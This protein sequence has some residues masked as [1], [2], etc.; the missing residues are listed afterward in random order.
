MIEFYIEDNEVVLSSDFS[1]NWTEE[2]PEVTSDGEFSLDMTISLVPAQNVIAFG[3][4]NRLNKASITKTVTAKL[5][6]DGGIHSGTFVISTNNNISVVGQFLSGNSE[7]KY[8]AKNENKIYDLDWGTETEIDYIRALDSINQPG[9]GK[10]NF[11]CTPVI[12]SNE[13]VN[14]YSIS[15]DT[16]ATPSAINGITGKIVMQPWLLYYINKLPELLGYTLT[17]NVLNTDKRSKIMYLLNSS[18]SLKYSDALPD[19]T[20]TEF[21][22]YI[23]QFFNVSFIVDPATK[24][25]SI[26]SLESNL[27]NKKTVT[28]VVLD[29][30]EREFDKDS[31]SLRLDFTRVSYDLNDSNYFRW[32][33]LSDVILKNYTIVDYANLDAIKTWLKTHSTDDAAPLNIIFYDVE[34]NNHYIHVTNIQPA[35]VLY[36]LPI[37]QDG[38]FDFVRRI[39]LIDKFSV[40]GTD[41]TKDLSF[42]II[43]AEMAKAY[44][45]VNINSGTAKAWFQLPKYSNPYY[46][47]ETKT[48]ISAVEGTESTISR[49]S[50]LEV[51]LYTGRIKTYFETNV[52]YVFDIPTLYP[53]SHVDFMPE[54]SG[55]SDRD[56]L[57]KLQTWASTYFTPAADTTMRIKNKD[58]IIDDYHY[59]SIIN[60][61][62]QYVFIMVDSPEV[63]ANNIFMIHNQKYFPISIEREKKQT[64]T[65][66]KGTFYRMI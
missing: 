66:A 13:V 43:P 28:P 15:S 14:F 41:S 47:P 53:F 32:N 40:V 58:G 35:A 6:I 9:Y 59:K 16:D 22:D 42:K 46:I 44:V 56:N 4:L 33:C 65:T 34:K 17:Y 62:M 27:S 64:E 7:L 38:D 49:L 48:L 23:E 61:D 63:H 31:L 8:I 2:N 20:I 45:S 3:F 26:H 57:I 29:S 51:A 12:L 18:G 36:T 21:K 19:W 52:G 11:I 10:Y 25:I 60:T 54:F 30:Y 55:S 24:S 1:F 39:Q 5:V 50:K 37:T